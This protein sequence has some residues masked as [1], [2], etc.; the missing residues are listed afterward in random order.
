MNSLFSISPYKEAEM[1]LNSQDSQYA[2]EVDN[3]LNTLDTTASVN[4]SDTLVASGR[5]KREEASPND[6]VTYKLNRTDLA[7]SSQIIQEKRKP[8]RVSTLRKAPTCIDY[9]KLPKPSENLELRKARL[10]NKRV[11]ITKQ[12]QIFEQIHKVTIA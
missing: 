12:K 9:A 8:F 2:F 4:T 1:P 3:S 6:F 5:A 7:N 10:E 11:H